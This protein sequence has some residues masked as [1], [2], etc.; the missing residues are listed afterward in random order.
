MSIRVF[1]AVFFSTMLFFSA[2]GMAESTVI[3]TKDFTVTTRDFEM[4]LQAN[5]F[6]GDRRDRAL[7]RE[8]AVE[9]V[10]ENLYLVR[11]LAAEA[12]RNPAIEKELIDWR[13]E[14]FRQRL[15]M[16]SQ[17]DFKVDEAMKSRDLEALARAEYAA[18]RTKYV[19][20]EIVDAS[21]ILVSLDERTEAQ[22]LQRAN[23][24]LGRIGQGEDFGVLAEEYS[25]DEGSAANAG[26]LGR[27]TRG[28]MVEPFEEAV[29]AL[30]DAGELAGPVQTRFGFHLIRLN[31]YQ[32]ERQL[33]Y[34]ES[35]SRIMRDVE[36]RARQ[37]ARQE[38]IDA[39]K[40]G[41]TDLGLEMNV[42]L[43]RELEER[44]SE[45]PKP[46]PF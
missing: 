34:E 38:I 32:P 27:F 37:S 1:L 3:T 17:L 35:K 40:T 16:D 43:L 39:V 22:A 45:S 10:F 19:Q 24:V 21:H 25:D 41:E 28:K 12:E 13:A 14:H 9:Q 11:A 2:N 42:P 33:S 5:D 36:K 20:R 26:E 23:E 8:G 18:N 44:Y 46:H 7:A 6:T 31:E 29:F 4:Y 30:R 15:L